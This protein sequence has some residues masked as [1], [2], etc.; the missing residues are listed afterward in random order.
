MKPASQLAPEALGT[1]RWHQRA[2]QCEAPTVISNPPRFRGKPSG[3]TSK[4]TELANLCADSPDEPAQAAH[5]GIDRVRADTDLAF[6]FLHH[7]SLSL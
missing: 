4:G 1:I 7:C 2:G 6:A 5:A 3:A